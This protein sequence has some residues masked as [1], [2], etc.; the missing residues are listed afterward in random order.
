MA[1]PEKRQCRFRQITDASRNPELAALYEEIVESGFGDDVPIN[2]FT[3]QSERPDI[4]A[5]TWTCFKALL[6]E[7]ILPPT[8]KQMIMIAISTH[9]DCQ[10]CKV[11]HTSALRALGVQEELIDNITSDL[12]L[13]KVPPQQRAILEFALKTARD[14][15]AVTD[16][17][18]EALRDY[19]LASGEIIEVAMLA[20]FTVFVNT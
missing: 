15:L 6:M 5:A 11:A 12:N 4:L 14:P 10:Y 1:D 20:A 2:W 7:G 17:D 19:G 3:S 9:N 8:I 18:V 16:A 13:A